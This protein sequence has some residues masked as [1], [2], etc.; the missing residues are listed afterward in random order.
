M[1]LA[2]AGFTTMPAKVIRPPIIDGSTIAYECRIQGQMECGDHTLYN[3]EVVA[4]HGDPQKA[5]HLFTIHYS[6]MVAI[7]SRGK[8]DVGIDYK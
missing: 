3:G 5:S 8:I 2:L 7:D 6:K 1:T 4:I